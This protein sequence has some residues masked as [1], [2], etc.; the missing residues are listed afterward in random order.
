MIDYSITYKEGSSLQPHGYV[1]SDYAGY[2][3][4]RRSTEENIFIVASEPVFW[5]CKRQDIVALSTVKAEFMAFSKA[6]TQALWISKYFDE[7]RLPVTKPLTIY[8]DYSSSISNSL[9]DKNHHRTKHIDVRYY[10]IKEHT[11]KGNVIFHYTPTTQNVT[12]ILTKPLPQDTLQKFVNCIGLN[13]RSVSV[14]EEY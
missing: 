1:D 10:F 8:A 7:V 3:D 9:N 14:Q 2:R 6:T 13:T 12:G 5:K 4:T 11:K